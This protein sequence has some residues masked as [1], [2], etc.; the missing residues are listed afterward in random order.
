MPSEEVNWLPKN[1]CK[2]GYRMRNG[3]WFVIL[4]HLH[5]FLS[6]PRELGFGF[7]H[8]RT[9]LGFWKSICIFRDIV[10]GITTCSA[11]VSTHFK[12]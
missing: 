8:P 6:T 7:R 10:E 11:Y 2:I 9:R 5:N 1:P 3:E 12:R 4:Q